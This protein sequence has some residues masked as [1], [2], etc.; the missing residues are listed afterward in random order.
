M[1]RIKLTPTLS[2]RAFVYFRWGKSLTS[3]YSDGSL[4]AT[5]H[6][7]NGLLMDDM[8]LERINASK[9]KYIE[10][11]LRLGLKGED[12]LRVNTLRKLTLIV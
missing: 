7:F 4:S 9:D 2:C 8:A 3:H 5:S 1:K 11:L 10:R 12:Q 6:K